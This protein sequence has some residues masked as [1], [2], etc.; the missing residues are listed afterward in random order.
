MIFEIMQI[1]NI[2][3]DFQISKRGNTKHYTKT[4][5]DL[6]R[7]KTNGRKYMLNPG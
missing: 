5:M 2:N 3:Y 4:A 7:S 6:L 1:G